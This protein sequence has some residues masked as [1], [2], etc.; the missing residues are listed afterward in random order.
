[1]N[2]KENIKMLTEDVAREVKSLIVSSDMNESIRREVNRRVL[3][4]KQPLIKQGIRPE[5]EVK[6]IDRAE[7]YLHYDAWHRRTR[8]LSNINKILEDTDFVAVVKMGERA[9]PFIYE[10]LCERPS[11]IAFAVPDIIGRNVGE[12]TYNMNEAIERVKTFIEE[13]YQV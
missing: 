9:I 3:E 11:F 13:N 6:D 2:N 7:F 5:I 4:F 1:M 10:I 12:P 8:F